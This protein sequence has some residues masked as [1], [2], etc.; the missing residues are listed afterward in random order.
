MIKL[1]EMGIEGRMFNW[2]SDSLKQ[3]TISVRVG[4][5]ISSQ[6]VIENGTS[7]GSP[8]LFII[9]ISNIFSKVDRNI[10]KSLFADDGALWFRGRNNKYIMGKMQKAVDEVVKWSYK[11]GFKFSVEK[12]QTIIFSN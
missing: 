10:G 6:G 1:E 5:S 11:W 12:S 8:V 9:M 4:D 7:Q 3:R 2:I